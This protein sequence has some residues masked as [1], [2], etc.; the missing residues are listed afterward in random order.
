MQLNPIILRSHL[1]ETES[2]K[3][4]VEVLAGVVLGGL[5]TGIGNSLLAIVELLRLLLPLSLEFANKITLSPASKCGEV[6]QAARFSETLHALHLESLRHDHALLVVVWVWDT[7]E[8]AETAEGGSA[9]GRFVGHHAA[10][11]LPEH[12]RRSLPMLEATARVGVDAPALLL[13]PLELPS[14][15]RLR[16]ID[17]F[18][19][20]DNDALA[21][22]NL[23]GNDACKASTEMTTPVNNYLFFEHALVSNK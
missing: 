13:L 20:D 6:T 22:E 3:R 8:E 18:A 11:G 7:V 10:D 14:E 19:A 17:L 9:T 12:A 15:E 2:G 5:S 4:L 21:A 16:N 1:S 23:G